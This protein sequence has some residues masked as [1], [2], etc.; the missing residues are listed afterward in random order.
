MKDFNV[1]LLHSG[2]F[3]DILK[4]DTRTVKRRLQFFDEKLKKQLPELIILI[5]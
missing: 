5:L 2:H 1:N 3:I 4:D